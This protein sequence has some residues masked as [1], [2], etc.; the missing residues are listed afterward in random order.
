MS[1]SEIQITLIQLD[2]YGPWTDTLGGDREHRLQILQASLYSSLQES[3]AERN[4]LV[5]FNRFDEMLAITNGITQREHE[6]I[7]ST[8]QERFPVTMSMAIGVGKNPFQAQVNASQLLQQRG[9]AQNPARRGVIVCERT[10]S[11]DNAHVQVM[12]F[13]VDGI[14]QTLTDH[15]SAYDTSLYV[16]ELYG[17]LM[18]LFRERDALIFFVG[19][20]NFMGVA[21]G[22]DVIEI[23]SVLQQYRDRN[24]KLKC[25]IGVA[26]TARKAAE[27]AAINLDQI[28]RANGGR[29]VLSTVDL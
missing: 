23:E 27:L 26:R 24:V 21:N 6:N 29:S 16:M 15:V 5:F 20:D 9:G 4:G 13:D 12:H 7:K 11:T 19:G 3:F 8:M 1:E 2:N 17:E 25:G 10:L 22:L 18:K 14:T 28:R